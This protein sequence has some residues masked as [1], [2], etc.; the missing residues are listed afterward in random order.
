[1]ID[2]SNFIKRSFIL[3]FTL[4][5]SLSNSEIVKAS[6]SSSEEGPMPT[7][8]ARHERLRDAVTQAYN[9]ARANLTQNTLRSLLGAIANEADYFI[10]LNAPLDNPHDDPRV[11]GTKKHAY[12]KQLFQD[13]GVFNNVKLEKN[14]G[15]RGA[16]PAKLDVTL[17]DKGT[18]TIYVYDYKFGEAGF[19]DNKKGQ[20]R[21]SLQTYIQTTSGWDKKKRLKVFFFEIS[22]TH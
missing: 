3:V 4:G 6:S 21:N 13:L 16:Y 18:N 2:F 12:A 9:R 7:V 19:T 1:M 14:Y 5:L 20:Y 17:E 10:D 11:A 22:P 8:T 15:A